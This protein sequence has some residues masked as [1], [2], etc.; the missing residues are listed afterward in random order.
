MNYY[1]YVHYTVDTKE[2]FYVGKGKGKR[3]S[4]EANRNKWWWSKVNK[5]KGFTSII[6]ASWPTEKEALIHE[7]FLIDCF[8]DM[9]IV[10]TN[11]QKTQGKEQGGWKCSEESRKRYKQAAILRW[12]ALTKEQQQTI[13]NKQIATVTGRPKTEEHKRNLSIARTGMSVPASY[14][15]VL[16]KTTGIIYSSLTEAAKETDCDISHIV[17]CCKGK[18]KKT[19]KME[20]CYV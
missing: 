2:I 14:I 10:L 15:S 9:G 13:R 4:Q 17:K 1:T 6:M 11:I 5:H 3:Y 18:L 20:W 8:E 7:K 19:K 12:A 16:C